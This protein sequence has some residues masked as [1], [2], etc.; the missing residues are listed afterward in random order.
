VHQCAPEI[1][2]ILGQTQIMN[3]LLRG[4]KIAQDDLSWTFDI[5][6]PHGH[7]PTRPTAL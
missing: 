6:V 5:P 1:T 2:E 3:R 4:I 7:R